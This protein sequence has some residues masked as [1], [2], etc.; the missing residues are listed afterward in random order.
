[1]IEKT[2][3]V[4][5]KYKYSLNTESELQ[6]EIENTLKKENIPFKR[7]L[8]INKENR[9]DFIINDEIALEVKI[10]GTAKNIFNQCKRYC[11]T[12][13]I[14]SLILVTRKHIGF[15]KQINGKDCYI[16]ILGKNWL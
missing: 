1:M 9:P 3:I 16:V 12:N 6:N 8:K 14:K 11:E 13:K 4:L 2:I 10:K 5:K 7:E 15:P